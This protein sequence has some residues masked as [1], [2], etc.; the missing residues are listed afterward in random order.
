ML[1]INKLLT[2]T[3]QKAE[4]KLIN[5]FYSGDSEKIVEVK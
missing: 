2:V 1:I 5:Y 3:L 4:I